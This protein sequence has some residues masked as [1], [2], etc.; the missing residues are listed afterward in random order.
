M[1]IS[2]VRPYLAHDSWCQLLSDH[3][4]QPTYP[5]PPYRFTMATLLK[6]QIAIEN[7]PPFLINWFFEK[8]HETAETGFWA[9]L[10]NVQGP[11]PHMLHWPSGSPILIGLS[12]NLDPAHVGEAKKLRWVKG[13]PGRKG[14]KGSKI[15]QVCHIFQESGTP[16]A[17]RRLAIW[18]NQF[19]KVIYGSKLLGFQPLQGK[20]ILFLHVSN[21]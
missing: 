10:P 11:L 15:H 13:E 19:L 6:W 17:W 20:T 1:M 9:H 2:V 3:L 8:P 21:T 14:R 12:S 5:L 18:W 7:P 16:S 4:H